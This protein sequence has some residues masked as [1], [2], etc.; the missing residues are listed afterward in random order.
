MAENCQKK[1][2]KMG[3]TAEKIKKISFLGVSEC[4]V[5][6]LGS[7]VMNLCKNLQYVRALTLFGFN[8]FSIVKPI[9]DYTQVLE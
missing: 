7:R 3:K 5:Y 1:Y 9:L 8:K 4:S 6:A 2:Q